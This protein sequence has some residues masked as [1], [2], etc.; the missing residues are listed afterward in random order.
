M[1][2]DELGGFSKEPNN[3]NRIVKSVYKAFQTAITNI[4]N[5]SS[6]AGSGL[7]A[8]K[9]GSDIITAS[10]DIEIGKRSTLNRSFVLSDCDSNIIE[11]DVFMEY[12]YFEDKD[13]DPFIEAFDINQQPKEKEEAGQINEYSKK[14]VHK[15]DE[16]QP[17]TNDDT[18]VIRQ[19]SKKIVQSSILTSEDTN[20]LVLS[21]AAI[22]TNDHQ[23]ENGSLKTK[24]SNST[25]FQT[26][27]K[28]IHL[29]WVFRNWYNLFIA[30]IK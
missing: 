2:R 17:P 8:L 1:I 14:F 22:I 3:T 6:T 11:N 15:D 16:K 27:Q 30:F 13:D 19:L 21:H 10:N 23:Q 12:A 29:H 28:R 4:S 26:S 7:Y 5:V 9:D 20:D 24:K 18:K 25:E